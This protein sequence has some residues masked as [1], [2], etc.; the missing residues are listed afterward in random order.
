MGDAFRELGRVRAP[1]EPGRGATVSR[2]L[3]DKRIGYRLRFASRV[4][5][6]HDAVVPL[7]NSK[8]LGGAED[9]DAV[10]LCAE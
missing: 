9:V 1:R 4:A 8:E 5:N 3:T 10:H 7:P 6:G 2:P